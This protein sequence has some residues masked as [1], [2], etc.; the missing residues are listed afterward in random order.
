[1]TT[2]TLT[3]TLTLTITDRP[4]VEALQTW[5]DVRQADPDCALAFADNAPQNFTE[6]RTRIVTGAYITNGVSILQTI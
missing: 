2:A 4:T 3:P 1:M 5:W 6:L